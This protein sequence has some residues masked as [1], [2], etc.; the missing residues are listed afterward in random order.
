[1]ANDTRKLDPVKLS[2]LN[3]I[4]DPKGFYVFGAKEEKGGVMKSGSCLFDT[5]ERMQLE[6]RI[7]LTMENKEI[8]IFIG[9][10]M[11]IY[12]VD[13]LNVKA[14]TIG[15]EKFTDLAHVNK[16]IDKCT[17]V[18]FSIEFEKEEE[19]A[20]LFIYAKAELP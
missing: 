11:T 20:Y 15:D 4:D 17:K 3:L 5:L 14:L 10:E 9:E 13:P 7:A 2:E 18:R 1:M 8:E 16:K 12:K 6:R 19:T